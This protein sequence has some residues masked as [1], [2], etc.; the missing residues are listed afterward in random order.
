MQA[1]WL[2]LGGCMGRRARR[3]SSQPIGRF[4][5]SGQR[6][7][8]DPQPGLGASRPRGGGVSGGGVSAFGGTAKRDAGVAVTADCVD[9]TPE[10]VGSPVLLAIGRRPNTDE[11]DLEAAGIAT[12]ERGYIVV[13]EQ[14]RTTVPGVW[15]MGDVNGRGAFTHTSWNDY[16]IVAANLL[17]NDPRRVSDRIAAYALFIDPPLGRVGLTERE[18]RASGRKALIGKMPM[19]RVGRAKERGETLGFMKVIVDAETKRI[20]GASLLGL[21]GD[22]VV[23]SLLDVMY[24]SAP[25][26]VLSRATHIHPTVSELIPTLLQNLKPLQ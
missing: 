19:T 9:G 18:V 3:E 13:D 1:R 10:I 16:E 8:A 17:D 25:Y 23:H 2:C 4:P 26:T 7:R 6:K 5:A 15:A 24:A 20:L 12:N 11:L 14:L 22:E 21:N